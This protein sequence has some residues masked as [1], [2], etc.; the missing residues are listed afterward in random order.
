MKTKISIALY[1][2]M[3]AGTCQVLAQ[4]P[5]WSRL[6]QSSS[7]GTPNLPCISGNEDYVVTAGAFS[8]PLNF[9]GT[10]MVSE[11]RREMFVSVSFTSGD[12]LWI[13]HYTSTE[14]IV[15]SAIKMD[16]SSN[17]FFTGGYSGTANIDGH[18]L[19]GT[20][21]YM[22]SLD[23]YGNVRWAV[24][25]AD[26]STTTS[27]I[28]VDS[29]GNSYLASNTNKLTKFAANGTI[30]WEQNFPQ[31]TLRTISIHENRLY[32]AG[33]L[34]VGTT[35][36]GPFTF[37]KSFKTGIILKATLDGEYFDFLEVGGTTAASN[38]SSVIS[39]END[40]DGNLIFTGGY[41]GNLEFRGTTWYSN[42]N[43]YYPF[44]AK[45][46][47]SL[48]VMW[49]QSGNNILYS[50]ITSFRLFLD[51]SRNIYTCGSSSGFEFPPVFVGN[52]YFF[53]QFDPDGN[54]REAVNAYTTINAAFL[55]PTGDY[56]QTGIYGS[57]NPDLLGNVFLRQYSW[58]G[59]LLWQK[60]STGS[61]AGS[62]RI[63]YGIHDEAGNLY[64][65]ARISGNGD[66]FGTP[67][68]APVPQTL[69]AKFDAF[70]K[71]AWSTAVTDQ[72][73]DDNNFPFGPQ[74]CVDNGGNLLTSGKFDT[75]L[76]IGS[77][78]LVNE[79]LNRDGYVVKLSPEGEVLWV[80]Q[81]HASDQCD[82][83]GT[84]TDHNGY[85]IVT[86]YFAGLLKVGSGI[87]DS[88]PNQ[89]VFVIKLDDQG[90]VL[91]AQSYPGDLIYLAMPAVDG[92]GN[93]YVACEFYD[94]SGTVTF[95][96]VSTPQGPED[97]GTVLAKIDPTGT[98]LWVRTFAGSALFGSAS[99][100]PTD[101]K[102]DAL[103]NCYLW[104][105][106]FNEVTFGSTTFTNPY[107]GSVWN[108][109]LAKITPAGDLDWGTVILEKAYSF[110]YG[111]MLDLDG[112][113]NIY[114]GGHFKDS[115]EV[116]GHQFT[117][118]TTNDLYLMK[119][120]N[121]GDYQWIK[122][123]PTGGYNINCMSVLKENSLTISGIAGQATAFGPFPVVNKGGMISVMATLGDLL[124][125]FV[126]V[127]SGNGVDQMNINIT[128]ALLDGLDLEHGDEIGVFDGELCVGAGVVD[129][130]ITAGN[131]L[132]L[133]VSR[134]DGTGNGYTPGHPITYR[135]FDLS[136]SREVIQVTAT[137]D[138]ENPEW[139]TSGTFEAGATAFAA[140]NGESTSL[141]TLNLREGWNLISSNVTSAEPDMEVLFWP[142]ISAS[143]LVKVMD[144]G[145]N[146]LED[147]GDFGGW[148]NSIGDLALTEG[149]KVKV[150]TDCRLNLEGEPASLPMDIPL[151]TGW[152][153]IGFPYP[154][155]VNAMDL[156]QQ[157]ITR[158][159][160]I[161]VQDE[162][163]HSIEDYGSYGGWINNI[164]SFQPGKGYKVRVNAPDVL[165]LPA[166]IYKSAE[167][168]LTEVAPRHF[169][170]V[171]RGNGVDH[172]NINL[173]GLSSGFLQPGDEIG[174]FDGGLCVGAVTVL[175]R[176]LD[177]RLI[178]IPASAADRG[179]N[180]GFTEGRPILLQLWKAS[181]GELLTLEP[182]IIKGS[183]SFRKNESL[184]ASLEKYAMTPAIL[185]GQETLRLYPNPTSGKITITTSGGAEA[186]REV[187][188]MNPAGQR[189]LDT[190]L[191][192][193]VGEID[194]SGNAPGLYYIRVTSGDHSLTEKITLR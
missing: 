24:P 72:P 107:A 179:D 83:Q 71:L 32:V 4:A 171:F 155:S 97:G 105:W 146:T 162:T 16:Q 136:A 7:Y 78:T 133:V 153:I 175:P 117:P 147:L 99:G 132:T 166:L 63:N 113:G 108:K 143:W 188:V 29:E 149:Y 82:I 160:L 62:V 1:I 123:V 94:N 156:M 112:N 144:E 145:G 19:S 36:I 22:A 66:F 128:S 148:Q 189:V 61:Q 127:W 158:G 56:F 168:P 45:C 88:G 116:Q 165:N 54:A 138:D 44:L 167:V 26:A 119:F 173:V 184:F 42:S 95:G 91:W 151:T 80:T 49:A 178:S 121:D 89:G 57:E 70:G 192:S 67:I 157:L 129:Q 69:F 35:T 55:S 141:L 109:Y 23:I 12:P 73:A 6:L 10:S 115:I 193:N 152:N 87:L 5:E 17:V 59:N 27:C 58:P 14:N 182:D 3:I 96:T 98:A 186:R 194:L 9:D 120:T 30:L 40:P 18:T 183:T 48:N 174:L 180:R 110:N 111:D 46:D 33:I 81:L 163:G 101:I 68:S 52:G 124:P 150:T 41:Y 122:T 185:P 106:C 90:N 103:G 25:L 135:Y 64:T 8:G 31:G 114:V 118:Q 51:N 126:P 169:L 159:T 74:V 172:M 134:N 37:T 86:G 50:N 142:L 131:L 85:V 93:I 100:W 38:G 2:L 20:N 176:H 21:G 191:E 104:G 170:P 65:S 92:D 43:A 34:P 181:T 139:S 47:T 11:G 125:H 177:A 84:V 53:L 79:N 60:I 76:K 164:G 137:Y 161:K 130:T 77:T 28:E 102:T 140:L 190:I 15:P 187:L 154:W 39:M 75:Q 13:R